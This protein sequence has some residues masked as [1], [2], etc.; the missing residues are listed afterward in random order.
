MEVSAYPYDGGAML[1]GVGGGTGSGK[2]TVAKAL[3]SSLQPNPVVLIALDNYYKDRPDLVAEQRA[4]QNFDHP[5][6]LDLELL[7]SH[8]NQLKMGKPIDVPIYDFV[9]HRRTD[10]SIKI[11]ACKVVILEG[12]LTLAISSIRDKLSIKIY[13]ETEDDI[14]FIR[15]L[16]RDIQERGRSLDSVI[17]QYLHQVRP[18]HQLYVE[19]SKRYADLIIPEGGRNKVAIDLIASRIREHLVSESGKGRKE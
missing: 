4:S 6:A 12:I 1:I 3:A 14:R 5:D 10:R 8:L 18:M 17:D 15:R 2:T 13:V 9:T 11:G 16:R 19:S 7:V